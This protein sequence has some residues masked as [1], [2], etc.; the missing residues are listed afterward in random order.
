MAGLVGLGKSRGSGITPAAASPTTLPKPPLPQPQ[1]FYFPPH[2]PYNE[3]PIPHSKTG[4]VFTHTTTY[5]LP[6]FAP[7]FTHCP[8]AA[9]AAVEFSQSTKYSVLNTFWTVI[10]PAANSP[11]SSPDH[12]VNANS[13]KTPPTL[14]TRTPLRRRFTQYRRTPPPRIRPPSPMRKSSRH[15]EAA[16]SAPT[17]P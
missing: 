1:K 3:I 5:H 11:S 9:H 13:A 7:G 4:L 8:P 6:S 10:M 2:R 16:N 12:A 15:T 17:R 14:R